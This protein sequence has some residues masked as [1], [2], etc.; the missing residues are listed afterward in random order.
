MDSERKRRAIL[1][2]RKEI[3][4]GPRLELGTSHGGST[5]SR[6]TVRRSPYPTASG[7]SK[8]MPPDSFTI[9]A[10]RAEGA[11]AFGIETMLPANQASGG[12][13]MFADLRDQAQNVFDDANKRIRRSSIVTRFHPQP[14]RCGVRSAG[15]LLLAASAA[16]A[17]WIAYRQVMA[18]RSTATPKTD[19]DYD[20]VDEASMESFPASDPPSFSPGAA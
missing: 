18:H 12:V 19:G 11:E 17:A 10:Q 7:P 1:K 5:M 15:M 14:N 2:Q 6:R 13:E 3:H 4:S 16:A 8:Q 20:S 9:G